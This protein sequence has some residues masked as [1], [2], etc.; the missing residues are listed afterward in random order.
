MTENVSVPTE[1]DV[2][3][4]DSNSDFCPL[5]P[6]GTALAPPSVPGKA[7][8]AVTQLAKKTAASG[9]L[10]CTQ[11]KLTPGKHDVQLTIPSARTA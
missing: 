9:K 5:G 7:S 1:G 8:A 3:A 4:T 11:K 10:L 6:S 2:E